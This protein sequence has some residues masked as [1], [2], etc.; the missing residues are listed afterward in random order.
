MFSALKAGWLLDAHDPDRTRSRRGDLCL[1]TI[2]S[3]LL[4]RFG[5]EHLI[6]LGNAARTQLLDVRERT[7]DPELL[8]LFGVPIEVLPRVV[9]STGPFPAVRDLAPVP[10]GT[11]VTGRDGRLARGALRARRLAPGPREGDLR[12]RLVDHGPRRAAGAGLQRPVPHDRLGR[13]AARVRVSR[14]TSAPPAPR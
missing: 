6:E 8:E 3:W 5:G 1:G 10:D 11:P 9:A 7:W 2:D 12:N 4:S 14:G 13:R